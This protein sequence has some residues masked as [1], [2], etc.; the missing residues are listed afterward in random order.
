MKTGKRV[1]MSK[2]AEQEVYEKV[3]AE[4]I[5]SLTQQLKQA[6]TRN[7]QLME[8]ISKVVPPMRELVDRFPGIK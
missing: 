2:K 5:E 8:L 3:Q 6:V 7:E 4:R 1:V